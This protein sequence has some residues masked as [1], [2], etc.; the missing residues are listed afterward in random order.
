[1]LSDGYK[2][3][4][5]AL[6]DQA[7]AACMQLEDAISG[8][9]ELAD[10]QRR[11][12]LHPNE[13]RHIA[14]LVMNSKDATIP[15]LTEA[16]LAELLCLTPQAVGDGEELVEPG[17]LDGVKIV[18]GGLDLSNS[19]GVDPLLFRFPE[20]RPLGFLLDGHVTAALVRAI[21]KRVGLMSLPSVGST[22]VCLDFQHLRDAIA[23]TRESGALREESLGALERIVAQWGEVPHAGVGIWWNKTPY[24]FD[25]PFAVGSR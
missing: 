24:S 11:M 3:A 2:V 19:V 5:Q 8:R 10:A 23:D 14:S 6:K 4:L 12:S 16:R 9:T 22:D 20:D 18:I 21:D 1:M 25:V 7:A 17:M 15:D 13:C